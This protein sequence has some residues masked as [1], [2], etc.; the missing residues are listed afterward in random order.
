[1]NR[2]EQI[3]HQKILESSENKNFTVFCNY[4]RGNNFIKKGLRTTQRRGRIQKYFCKDCDRFF[5]FDDGFWRMRNNR[6]KITQTIDTYY[7]GL[8]SRKCKRNLKRYAETKVSHVTVHL[9][10]E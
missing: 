7:E 9:V 6:H 10:L 2:Q 3:S 4:C 8:S 5:S 1:M